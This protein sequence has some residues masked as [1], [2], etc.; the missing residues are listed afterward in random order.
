MFEL[1]FEV[2]KCQSIND[3]T[4]STIETSNMDYSIVPYETSLNNLNDY[5]LFELF[6]HLSINELLSIKL[7]NKRFYFLVNSH[8]SKI[9]EV[10][11]HVDQNYKRFES[12]T[13]H[14]QTELN[15]IKQ[16]DRMDQFLDK[17]LVK[18]TKLKVLNLYFLTITEKDLIGLS[19]LN[20][21]NNTLEHLEISFCEF[22]NFFET[23]KSTYERFFQNLGK[24]LKHFIFFKNKNYLVPA[25][26]LFIF[27]NKFLT[28]L[29]TLVLDLKQYENVNFTRTAIEH[30]S[31]I[32]HL[33]LHG[34]HYP[35][36]TSLDRFILRLLFNKNIEYLNLTCI[37][38]EQNSLFTVLTNC[39]NL[40][41]LKFSYDFAGDNQFGRGLITSNCIFSSFHF[42]EMLN[43][44][45]REGTT[46]NQFVLAS[47]IVQLKQLEELHLLETISA[48]V[49]LDPLILFLYHYYKRN[50]LRKLI[51]T[52]YDLHLLNLKAF[53]YVS[54][55][56]EV[57]SIN[58]LNTCPYKTH[59]HK[60]SKCVRTVNESF[61]QTVRYLYD[62]KTFNLNQCN[63]DI[64]ILKIL[65]F[66][67]STKLVNF[68]FLQ[69]KNLKSDCI[70]QFISYAYTHSDKLITV[71]LDE[72][73][74]QDIE[75]DFGS[76]FNICP[77]NLNI[78]PC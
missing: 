19:K 26:H 67:C 34:F 52:N 6:N 13:E 1:N 54:K 23:A 12:C 11:I 40:K 55:R 77:V 41:V 58:E 44:F 78:I 75:K 35:I 63:F 70:D 72:K 51:I 66:N 18:L 25:N 37:K 42:L 7:I 14:P 68:S 2:T 46:I 62:L 15:S 3:E 29:E 10:M 21:M 31:P 69:N 73:L 53:C 49:N 38:M 56:L 28:N 45:E 24:K 60:P 39:L 27:I 50:N 43:E 32:K 9:K 59:Q 4:S 36:H 30:T 65:L 17:F 22:K 64:K 8:L 61:A 20:C 48:N 33:S 57:L 74:V 16:V 47:K 76:L 5:C 71:K